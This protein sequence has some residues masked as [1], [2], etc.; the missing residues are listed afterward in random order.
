MLYFQQ[1][2]NLNWIIDNWCL[3]N[4]TCCKNTILVHFIHSVS[5]PCT[6]VS[7]YYI[8][9]K[10][11]NK[12]AHRCQGQDMEKLVKYSSKFISLPHP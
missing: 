3:S 11:M 9:I 1:S 4:E 6:W 12:L 8:S 5:L 10:D 2:A 7:T